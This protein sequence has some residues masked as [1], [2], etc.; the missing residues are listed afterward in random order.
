[1][2]RDV[3]DLAQLLTTIKGGGDFYIFLNLRNL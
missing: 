1:M 3:V 2:S